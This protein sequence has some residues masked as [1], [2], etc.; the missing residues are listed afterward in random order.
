MPAG[1]R[2]ARSAI[3]DEEK[4]RCLIECLLCLKL[5]YSSAASLTSQMVLRFES[6][7]W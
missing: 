6:Y 5:C 4:K 7:P 2:E 1:T 3:M